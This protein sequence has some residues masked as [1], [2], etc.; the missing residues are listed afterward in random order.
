MGCAPLMYIVAVPLKLMVRWQLCDLTEAFVWSEHFF[1]KYVCS[2]ATQLKE[3]ALRI[4]VL[5]TSF[6]PQARMR[7]L[8]GRSC[9]PYSSADFQDL[10]LVQPRLVA[11][12]MCNGSAWKTDR[13]LQKTWGLFWGMI[14]VGIA[15][16]KA[17]CP[18]TSQEHDTE[19]GTT[20]LKTFFSRLR[21]P[22]WFVAQLQKWWKLY[23]GMRTQTSFSSRAAFLR[24]CVC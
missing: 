5:K 2:S 20:W 12:V 19:Q 9:E 15:A 1:F 18:R 24:S 6:I 14:Q 11:S 22:V 17:S 3:Q 23:Q 13:M 16:E 10:N 21:S 8:S 4:S 7:H